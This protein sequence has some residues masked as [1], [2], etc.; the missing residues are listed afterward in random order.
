LREKA[1]EFTEEERGTWKREYA[2][3]VIILTIPL[4][5]WRKRSIKSPAA[6]E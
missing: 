1:I 6:M 2:D 5:P 3:D 4:V